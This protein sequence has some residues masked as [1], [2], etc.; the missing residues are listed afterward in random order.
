MITTYPNVPLLQQDLI[1]SAVSPYG[2]SKVPGF[3]IG[4]APDVD[5]VWVD[6]WEGPTTTYVFPTSA[7]QMRVV[8]SSINDTSAGTGARTV[9]IHYLDNDYTEQ[10]TTVTLNGT[11]SV[12]TTPTN[13][14]RINR[15]HVLTA[16]SSGYNEGNISLTNLAGTVTYSYISAT[17]TSAQQA[18]YTVPAGKYGYINHWQ[19]SAGAVTGT[20]YT[21]IAIKAAMTE[22][23]TNPGVFYM[24]DSVGVLNGAAIMNLPIPVRIPPTCDVKMSAISDSG[25]ANVIALGSIFG[26]FE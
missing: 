20:H 19:A 17:N 21:Q 3:I 12:T 6:I 5:N 8:S 16:G 1:G 13:I 10:T 22:S 24:V 26:W 7:M 15:L 18:I 11:S 9:E 2:T 25:S 4:R 23:G 14:L